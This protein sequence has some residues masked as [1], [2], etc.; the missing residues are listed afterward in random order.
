MGKLIGQEHLVFDDNGK[1]K[2]LYSLSGA[3]AREIYGA[4]RYWE[5]VDHILREYAQVHP[6]EIQEQRIENQLTK[7]NNFNQ[8]ASNESGSFRQ[9]LEVPVGLFTVLTEY[10]EQMFNNKK[11]LHEFMKRYPLFTTAKTI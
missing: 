6:G 9:A 10:D 2:G 11:T 8:Y 5:G 3:K 7:D 4:S 1:F